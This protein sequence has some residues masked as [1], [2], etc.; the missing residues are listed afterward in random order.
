MGANIGTTITAQLVSLR[1][2]WIAPI[3]LGIGIVYILIQLKT[4]N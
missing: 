4:K 1:F 3:A 2:S